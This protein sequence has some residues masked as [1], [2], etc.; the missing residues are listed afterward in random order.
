MVDFIYQKEKGLSSKVCDKL[1][2]NFN[3]SSKL[4]EEGVWLGLAKAKASGDKDLIKKERSNPI[5][6]STDICFNPSFQKTKKW[7]PVLS[8]VVDSLYGSLED[9]FVRYK[10]N[11]FCGE[12]EI[13]PFFNMQYYKPGEGY[14]HMHIESGDLSTA[15]RVITWMIYLNSVKQ[16]GETAFPFQ[17]I[18]CTP[19]KGK[20]VLWPASITHPHHGVIAPYEEKYILTGWFTYK[21]KNENKEGDKL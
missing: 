9:Y 11:E 4:H 18:Y 19:K 6:I 10:T 8:K 1:I 13:Y 3:K 15:N 2:K 7:G 16:K 12:L 14:P 5:K 20:I 17:N 21:R